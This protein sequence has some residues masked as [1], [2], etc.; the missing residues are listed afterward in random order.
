MAPIPLLVLNPLDADRLARIAEGG[1]APRVALG[2]E[3][4]AQAIAEMPGLRCVLTNGATGFTAAEMDALP[5]LEIICAI[6]V[7]HENIDVAA[8]RARGIVVTHGPGTN[9]PSVADHAMALTLAL[10]RD[11]PRLDAAVKRGEWMGVRWPRPM[12]SGRR[13]GILGM[14]EIGAM[15]AARAQGGF[16]MEIAYHNRRP[17]AGCAHAWMESAHALAAWADVLLIAAPGGAGTRHLVDRAVLDALGPAGYLVNIGRGSVVDQA[18]LIAALSESR[19]AGAAIDVVDG[20]PE[21]PDAMR[22]LSNLIITPHIAGRSPES[23]LAT[24]SLVVAN[25]QAHFAGR[26]VLTPVP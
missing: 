6:A 14:G 22:A 12:V 2:A 16:G 9:A 11:I 1:F 18:A 21:V 25:L 7:G 8:A 5:Q 3:A 24:A 4:R 13:L 15:I 10:L 23:I 17:R 20:E 26:P 19:I